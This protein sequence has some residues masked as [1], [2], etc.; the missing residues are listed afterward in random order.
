M[1]F[2]SQD[3]QINFLW[4]SYCGKFSIALGNHKYASVNS[5][6]INYIKPKI[7]PFYDQ[8]I[9]LIKFSRKL[10]VKLEPCYL[11]YF[12]ANE[13]RPQYIHYA[14]E[15]KDRYWIYKFSTLCIAAT[16]YSI[17]SVFGRL[18]DIAINFFFLFRLTISEKLV[19]KLNNGKNTLLFSLLA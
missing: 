10:E 17:L 5:K 16:M 11:W 15:K 18:C 3:I 12:R 8:K 9:C 14:T 7:L 2:H 6:E 4:I 13:I 1:K 19:K